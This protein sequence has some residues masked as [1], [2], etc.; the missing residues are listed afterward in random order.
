MIVVTRL[1]R[2]SFAV[3]PDLIERIS[4]N[5]DTTL[6]MVD[7]ATYI[8][9]EPLQDI[10]GLIADSRA[11][12]I[13]LARDMTSTPEGTGLALSVVRPADPAAAPSPGSGQ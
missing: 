8:V 5:P 11:R 12:V 7:G 2:R 1:D 4:S 3:N 10:I 6:H 9:E 13:R